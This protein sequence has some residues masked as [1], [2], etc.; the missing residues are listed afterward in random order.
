MIIENIPELELYPVEDRG[1]PNLERVAIFVRETTDIGR[2]GLM[3][4]HTSFDRSATPFQDNLF[5]F[6]NGI[7]NKGDWILLYTGKGEPRSADWEATGGKVY[8]IH[9][10]RERTMFAN[11]NVI[12]ILFRIDAANIGNSP[13]DVPQISN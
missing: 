3:V 13:M 1:K 5:W 7:V 12:P 4:A 6:G 10:G 2:Y 11:T 9:W 8:S